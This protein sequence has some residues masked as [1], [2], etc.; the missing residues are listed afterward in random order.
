MALPS[1][2][3]DTRP[4]EGIEQLRREL[5]EKTRLLEST[6][7]SLDHFVSPLDWI[8]DGDG[9]VPIGSWRNPYPCTRAQG[10]TD[11]PLPALSETGWQ[12]HVSLARDL[13]NRNHL[14]IGFRDHVANFIGPVDVAFVL[15]GQAPGATASGPQDAAGDGQPDV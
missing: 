5:A 3:R 9:F 14:A 4:T 7:L 2:L 1:R 13:L 12:L 15:R 10:R 6:L 8:D 11:A